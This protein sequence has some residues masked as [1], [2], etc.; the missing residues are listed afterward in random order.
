MNISSKR[1]DHCVGFFRSQQNADAL[2]NKL[3]ELGLS[4]WRDQIPYSANEP[5][6]RIFVTGKAIFAAKDAL[7]TVPQRD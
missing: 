5:R 1:H 2:F 4:P 6:F 7:G 3:Q